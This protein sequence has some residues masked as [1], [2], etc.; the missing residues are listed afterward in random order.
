LIDSYAKDF[1]TFCED[2]PQIVTFSRFFPVFA[3][4]Y[5]TYS[6]N[7]GG[8][9]PRYLSITQNIFILANIVEI[10]IDVCAF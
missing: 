2:L 1:A 3:S 8:V 10:D 4:L 5:G 6:E 9:S 7:F